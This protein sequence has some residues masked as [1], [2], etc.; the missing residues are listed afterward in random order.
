MEQ[1]P[2]RGKKNRSKI[3]KEKNKGGERMIT[4]N[5]CRQQN[6]YEFKGLST[7]TK[8]ESCGVNSLFFELDTGD[9]YYFT[10]VEWL[11]VGDA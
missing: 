6:E 9:F 3:C 5:D 2:A 10:G 4:I 8:P 7:D 1:S 11:K